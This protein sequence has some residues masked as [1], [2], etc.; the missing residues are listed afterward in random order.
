MK[1]KQKNSINKP[2]T[3]SVLVSICILFFNNNVYTQK[4]NERIN[5][6]SIK[7]KALDLQFSNPDSAISMY[8]SLCDFYIRNKN[9]EEY[10]NVQI[11]LASCYAIQQKNNDALKLYDNCSKYFIQKNDSL[12][13]YNVYSEIGRAH[14]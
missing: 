1:F 8:N 6:D 13:L 14:V 11:K 7:K 10:Y 5:V 12:N 3:F 9:L 4:Q 2:T